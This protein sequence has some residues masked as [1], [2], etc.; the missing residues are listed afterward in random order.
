MEVGSQ[1]SDS[2]QMAPRT[3]IF[4]GR[5][6]D[7]CNSTE[8]QGLFEKYGTVTECDVIR[9]YGFVHMSSPEEADT[10][11]KELNN[12]N[13]RGS[14]ISVEPSTSKLHPEP[15]APGRART[16]GGGPLRRGGPRNGYG[17]RDYYMDRYYDYRYYDDYG[18]DLYYRPRPYPYVYDRRPPSP[19]TMS[20]RDEAYRRTMTSPRDSPYRRA[21]PPPPPPPPPPRDDPYHRRLPPPPPPPPLDE[22]DMYDR[23]MRDRSSDYLYSR[24]SP[25]TMSSSS[26]RSSWYSSERRSPNM[27]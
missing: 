27:W 16:E 20:Y 13:L 1:V 9:K 6:P 3:K 24:R 25:T 23:H 12:Y 18:R 15:G 17:L 8:L 14:T 19:P 7:D 21:L 10:A 26:Y 5:L 2:E 11:I 4:V 22:D